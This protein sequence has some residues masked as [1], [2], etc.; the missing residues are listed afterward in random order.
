MNEAPVVCFVTSYTGCPRVCKM[1]STLARTGYKVM[2]VEWDR[3]SKLEAKECQRNIIVYRMKL[4]APY[5][6]KLLLK[7]PVWWIYLHFLT[8]AK[9]FTVVQPQNLDNLLAVW[10]ISHIKHAKIIYDLADFYADAYVPNSRVLK[11]VTRWLERILIRTVD[12]LI[13]VSEGQISQVKRGNLP[14]KLA[15]VYNTL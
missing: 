7:M 14:A 13:L 10:V 4:K 3:S 11:G 6:L 8:I 9:H 12:G 15:L 5:G 2:M 1:V